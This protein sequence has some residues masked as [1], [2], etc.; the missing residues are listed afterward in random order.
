MCSRLL[1]GA[2]MQLSWSNYDSIRHGPGIEGFY[3]SIFT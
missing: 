1:N 3:Y 2:F